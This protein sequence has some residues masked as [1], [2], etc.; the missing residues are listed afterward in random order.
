MF[1]ADE[2]RYLIGYT[3]NIV[4]DAVQ[5][6]VRSPGSEESREASLREIRLWGRLLAFPELIIEERPKE[7]KKAKDRGLNI[8]DRELIIKVL[9][10]RSLDVISLSDEE[11]TT[12]MFRYL[13]DY[14]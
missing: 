12:R 1:T 13:R 6:I 5:A 11:L 3:N 10:S 14:Q 7:L 8:F 4:F 2:V 9:G